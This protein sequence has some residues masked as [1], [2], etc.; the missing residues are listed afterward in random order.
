MKKLT[1]AFLCLLVLLS[2]FGCDNQKDLSVTC[3]SCGELVAQ[4]AKF[5]PSCGESILSSDEA[6]N[7]EESDNNYDISTSTQT[8]IIN[9]SD[10]IETTKQ[11]VTTNRNIE[12]N[13]EIVENNGNESNVPTNSY[14]TMPTL[15][16]TANKYNLKLT[17]YSE[18]IYI[19]MVG[20]ET[21]TYDIDDNSVVGCEWGDWDGDTIP[22]TITPMS[23]GQTTVAVIIEGTEK[24]I[25]INIS[26]EMSEPTSSTLT[27][28]G[29]GKAYSLYYP[30]TLEADVN[31]L[32]SADYEIIYYGSD[33]IGIEVDVVAETIENNI[34]DS[35]YIG[36]EYELYNEDDVCVQTGSVWI[37]ANYMN[38]KYS[39]TINFVVDPGNYTLIFKDMYM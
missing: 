4:D 24:S 34:I 26:V 7:N 20:G 9:N 19:T 8:E 15:S 18:T 14:S 32:H 29:V 31:Y 33:K 5:C 2:L 13:Q 30:Y 39:Q 28:V 22:L 21:V 27:V 3:Q 6:N 11:T 35:N 12:T 23:S 37:D 38:R 17:D 1:S 25:T 36:I 10:D 16:I